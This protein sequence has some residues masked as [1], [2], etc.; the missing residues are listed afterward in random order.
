MIEVKEQIYLPSFSGSVHH[1]SE[2]YCVFALSPILQNSAKRK[3]VLLWHIITCASKSPQY[4]EH[5][6]VL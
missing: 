1:I 6:F 2:A 4:Q 5:S 3:K